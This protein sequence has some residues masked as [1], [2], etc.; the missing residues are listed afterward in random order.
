MKRSDR[1]KKSETLEV[2][3][4]HAT[5]QAFMLRCRQQGCSASEVV[6]RFIE[7][8]LTAPVVLP[9]PKQSETR[10]ASLRRFADIASATLAGLV[11]VGALTLASITPSS[12]WPDLR[13]TFAELDGNADGN[14]DLEEFL[15]RSKID[16]FMKRPN[17]DMPLPSGTFS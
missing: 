15:A 16:V 5:K 4:S 1:P 3:L 10:M 12:A 14:I 9:L 7:D 6:R 17:Q 13:A 8:F 11:A 2:R